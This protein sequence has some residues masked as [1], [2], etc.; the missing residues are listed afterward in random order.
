MDTEK[1]FLYSLTLSFQHHPCKIV[2][3]GNS[4][5][6]GKK[7]VIVLQVLLLAVETSKTA[8]SLVSSWWL[9]TNNWTK[10]LVSHCVFLSKARQWSFHSVMRVLIWVTHRNCFVSSNRHI[11]IT[12]CILQVYD[13]DVPPPKRYSCPV[14]NMEF[15]QVHLL[16]Y[17]VDR[18][19]EWFW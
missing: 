9:I 4:N 12:N 10:W 7:P 11:F 6:A 15:P 5:A 2:K 17:H 14:C 13:E 8:Y 16:Q 19:L 1:Q 18:C 3:H